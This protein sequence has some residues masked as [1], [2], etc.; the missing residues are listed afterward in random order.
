MHNGG[1]E[2]EKPV[3]VESNDASP[4][5]EFNH[6]LERKNMTKREFNWLWAGVLIQAFC[7]SFEVQTSYGISGYVN[8]YLKASSLQAVLPTVQAVIATAMVPLY[9][10]VSDVFG[11][12]PSLTF[13]FVCYLT[14]VTIEGSARSFLQLAIGQMIYALGNTGV[15]ALS[16]VVIADTTSLLTR[17]I[18]FAMYDVGTIANIWISQAL[19]DPITL[20]GPPDKWRIGYIAGGVIS[21]FGALALLFPLWYVQGQLRRRNVVQPPRKNLNWLAHEFDIPGAVLLTLALALVCLPLTLAKRAKG[22]WENPAIIIMLCVGVLCFVLLFLWETR[23]ATRPIL[24]IKVWTNRTAFGSLMVMFLLKF[25]GHVA[26]QYLTQYFVVS[27]DLS[28]GDA[29]MLVRGYQI[30]WLVCQLIAALLLKRYK[31]ARLMV[32]FGVF[33][34]CLGIGLM[35]PAR[36]RTAPTAFIVVAQVLGGAGAGFAHLACSVLVTGV[37]HK[38]DI[39]SV[40]GATQILI[41]F[42]S[43]IG[44]AIGGAIWTQYLPNRLQARVTSAFDERRAMNDPLEY[45][46]FLPAETKLQVIEAYSDAIKLMSIVGLAFAVL[47]LACAS[48]LQHVDLEQ[49]QDTQD[50]IAMG[51]EPVKKVDEEVLETKD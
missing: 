29:N 41:W 8:A 2:E 40:V 47:T 4:A 16:Q 42:G 36:H 9:T 33:V 50:L 11:R 22:N 6:I 27:R 7:M 5:E 19:I 49:D 31:K 15:Q 44:G 35:I 34:Y 17:G 12:A 46:R 10:K 38:R 32:W 18:M 30:G 20:G 3:G 14:G 24:S 45:V 13:A 21:G 43:G 51:E 37:V 39:A 48:L 28:F 26:W 25:M 23:Y 1:N